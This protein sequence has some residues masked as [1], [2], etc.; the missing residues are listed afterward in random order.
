MTK[1]QLSFIDRYVVRFLDHSDVVLHPA[2]EWCLYDD[3]VRFYGAQNVAE[4]CERLRELFIDHLLGVLNRAVKADRKAIAQLLEYRVP[5]NQALAD[6]PTIQVR[7]CCEI[8][9]YA[10]GLLG[11]L[12]GI[13]GTH[14]DGY[15]QIVAEYDVECPVHGVVGG[16]IGDPCGMRRAGSGWCTEKLVLGQLRGFVRTRVK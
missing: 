8:Q 7:S 14:D 5:C 15:S 12:S 10:V 16:H 6:D 1:V 4:W 11:L 13:A 2:G 9:P 3:V